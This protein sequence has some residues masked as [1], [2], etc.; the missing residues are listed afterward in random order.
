MGPGKVS[1]AK[2]LGPP[3]WL[4]AQKIGYYWANGSGMAHP[5]WRQAKWVG[6]CFMFGR[7]F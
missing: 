7:Q 1:A 2:V 4:G 6:W 5:V 3:S